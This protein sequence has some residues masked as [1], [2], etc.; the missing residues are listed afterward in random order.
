MNKEPKN[1]NDIDERISVLKKKKRQLEKELKY[2]Q[3]NEERKKRTRRLIET[4]AL[5]EKY[6]EISPELNMEEREELFKMFS[7]FITSNKPKKFKK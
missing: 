7:N 5:V 4:G 1:L 2:R 6:F 3:E